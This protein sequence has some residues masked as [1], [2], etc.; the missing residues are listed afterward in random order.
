[1]G[2]Y[3]D[4]SR[5]VHSPQFVHQLVEQV[6]LENQDRIAVVFG[7]H[8]LTY[9]QLNDRADALAQAILYTDPEAKHIGVSTTRNLEMIIGV[10]AILKSGKAYL[11]LDPAYPEHRL[12]QIKADSGLRTCLSTVQDDRLFDR[13]GFRLSHQ[14]MN[15]HNLRR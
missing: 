6:S 12:Q 2:V 14:I 9:R 7:G 5:G 11:P 8:K 4:I 13:L 1:M 15:T 10:L 3:K